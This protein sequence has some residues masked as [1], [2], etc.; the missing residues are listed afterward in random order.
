MNE[1]YE[2][3]K[4]FILE[5]GNEVQKK[6][7]LYL[8]GECDLSCA[9]EALKR[10][11]NE[12][13]GWA[14]GLEIEY[15][16]NVSTPMTTAAA[17]G[18]I[19]L[20][21]LSETDIFAKTLDY[22]SSTQKDDGSW[23]DPEEITRFEL[24]PY[25]GPGIYVEFKTGMI[26]KWLSR[27]N[28]NTEDRTMIRRARDYLIEE[29]PRVSK[30]DDMWSAIAYI[31]AFGELPPSEQLK[32]SE[33]MPEIM[34]WAM[35]ILMPDGPPDPDADELEWTFVQGMIHDDSP[36]LDSM[37]E[38]VAHAIVANQLQSGGWQH[39]FGTYNAVWAAILIVRFLLRNGFI[40][41][42]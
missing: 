32:Q 17:L 11:Q 8:T 21:D 20:F 6:L 19:Y 24:P 1:V 42:A 5:N 3:A 13:G 14:N 41:I 26:I 7:L 25:M 9:V 39:Q 29:F 2:N 35:G 36:V 28:L 30:E 40:T 23:D 27:M 38:R 22:L 12:D 4:V 16:G 34:G 33:R 10:Y 37:K 31:N 15:G 18:Y